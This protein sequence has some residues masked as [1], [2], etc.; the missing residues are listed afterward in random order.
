L[1]YFRVLQKVLNR[2]GEFVEEHKRRREKK[3]ISRGTDESKSARR[4]RKAFQ[5]LKI[6]R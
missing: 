2:V 3:V 5:D 4:R 6:W 1:L